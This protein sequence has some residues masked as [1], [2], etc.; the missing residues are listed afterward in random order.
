MVRSRVRVR[1]ELLSKYFSGNFDRLA[2]LDEGGEVHD[3]IEAALREE[4]FHGWLI[5]NVG[6]LELGLAGDGLAPSHAEVVDHGDVVP[7]IDQSLRYHTADVAGPAGHQNP[8]ASHSPA[9]Q[10]AG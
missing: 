9:Q 8:H 1:A 3:S 2:G 4:G 5:A 6:L 7:A 10:Y